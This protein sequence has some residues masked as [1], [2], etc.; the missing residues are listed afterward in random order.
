MIRTFVKE[1]IIRSV[2]YEVYAKRGRALSAGVHQ[3][4]VI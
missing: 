1:N 4:P 2:L 3:E